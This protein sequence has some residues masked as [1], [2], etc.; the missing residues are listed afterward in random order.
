LENTKRFGAIYTT[1]QA[2]VVSAKICY[3]VEQKL[4][5]VIVTGE[6]G[7]GKSTLAQQMVQRWK[8]EATIVPAYLN[9]PDAKYAAGFQR[10]IATAFGLPERHLAS[11]NEAALQEFLLQQHQA[12]RICVLVI[13]NAHRLS[14][15]GQIALQRLFGWKTGEGPLLQVVLFAQPVLER[16]LHNRAFL[17]RHVGSRA[18]LDELTFKDALGMLRHRHSGA[19][20]DRLLPLSLHRS[21]Y[22]ASAGNPRALCRLCDQVFAEAAGTAPTQTYT[23]IRESRQWQPSSALGL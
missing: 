11:E 21:L 14:A 5:L 8:A 2:E 22:A 19:D 23:T 6:A 17:G 13:D 4:G 9:R 16:R 18:T 12:G 7:T 15:N 20:F 1:K 10:Q 3:A